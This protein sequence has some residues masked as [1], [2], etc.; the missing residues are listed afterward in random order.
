MTDDTHEDAYTAGQRLAEDAQ[1]LTP[2]QVTALITL[3][4]AQHTPHA[5]PA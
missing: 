4:A 5:K 3:L 1:P 2:E